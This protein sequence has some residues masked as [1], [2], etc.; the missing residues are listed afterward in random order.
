MPFW[1]EANWVDN[2]RGVVPEIDLA[3]AQSALIAAAIRT[4]DLIRG[5]DGQRVVPQLE[6]SVA[7]TAAH[8]VA[9]LCHSQAFVTG[10]ENG[11]RYAALAGDAATPAERSV[12]ANAQILDEFAERDVTRLAALLPR[13]AEE[14][15]AVGGRRRADELVVIETGQS[16]TVPVMT[17]ILLGEQLVH[18]LDIARA[19]GRQWPIDR[20][21]ALIVLAG[22]VAM[23][24]EVI[25]R[26]KAAHLHATFEVR[27]RGG[28]R[29]RV[30]IDDGVVTLGSTETVDF[31]I[32]AD[33]VASLLLAYGRASQWAEMLRGHVIAGGRKPWLLLKGRNLLAA[34]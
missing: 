18:G 23:L 34:P 14:F 28:P 33:P 7:E 12:V 22:G 20:R 4:A 11:Y 6:W 1:P 26:A 32:S 8:L 25:N 3:G 24:P 15:V 27:L 9:E 21:D 19:L 10:D 2:T 16:M 31:W 30:R 17:A 13:A 29:Y 5:A